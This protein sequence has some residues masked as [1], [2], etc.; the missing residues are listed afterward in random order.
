MNVHLQTDMKKLALLIPFTL[1][2]GCAGGSLKPTVPDSS[3]ARRACRAQEGVVV[4]LLNV[5]IERN[6]E[7]AQAAGAAL[8]GYI[9]N[10]ATRNSN[11]ITRAVVTVAGAAAGSAVGNTVGEHALNRD[12]VELLV[13]VNGTTLSIVQE[14]D[15]SA[16]FHRGD[17]VWVIGATSNQRYSRNRC[18]SG[19]RVLPRS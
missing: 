4:D 1:L 13:D 2:V 7:T 5:N 3:D 6:I 10:E 14:L 12:G 19:T 16:T 17:A 8:G 18:S 11:D 9:A 15:P